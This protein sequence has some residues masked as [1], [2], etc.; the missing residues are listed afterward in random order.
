MPGRALSSAAPHQDLMCLGEI[1][2]I[3]D[4]VD[5]KYPRMPIRRILLLCFLTVTLALTGPFSRGLSSQAAGFPQPMELAQSVA[6]ANVKTGAAPSKR[7]QRGAIT[8]ASCS[9][10]KGYAA[11]ISRQVLGATAARYDTQAGAA[12]EYLRS[13]RIFRPPRSS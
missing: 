6:M 7:C 4:T 1:R 5:G 12:A 9:F 10:D 8:W 11:A 13:S 2:L 3:L